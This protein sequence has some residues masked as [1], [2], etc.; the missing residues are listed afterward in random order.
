MRFADNSYTE[1]YLP[2]I[3]VDFK[4]RTLALEDKQVKLSIWDTAGQERFRTITSAYYRGANG[5]VLVFDITNLD[6][7]KNVERWMTDVLRYS[8]P[9][10]P[11]ILIGN[12]TDAISE[13]QVAYD[14]ANSFAEERGFKYFETSAKD[15]SNV[16]PSFL[17][18]AQTLVKK[19]EDEY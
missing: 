16:D 1:S 11:V 19:V 18:L 8:N 10:V 7:Y 5:I 17:S 3:G 13:R 2:T 9:D 4:I 6:S 12:K 15:S 14:V